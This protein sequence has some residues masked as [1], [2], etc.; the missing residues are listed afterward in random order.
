MKKM[1][2]LLF[3]VLL[4]IPLSPNANMKLNTKTE[5]FSLLQEAFETQIS[6]S[7]KTRTKKEIIELLD[8]YFSKVYQEL[9]W[10]ENIFEE[11]GEFV[12]YGS[13]FA[14]YYIPFFQYSNKTKVVISSDRIYVFEFFPAST[15]GPVGYDEH[16]EGVLLNKV[17]GGWKVDQFLYN[18][19][20][21]S[22]LEKAF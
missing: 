14:Q 1:L 9:F 10:N 15:D 8:P 19:I 7:E 20:P 22:V 13:D 4:L 18:N 17:N 3:V 16:Y 2:F 21:D 6:L 5:V 12:T 11:E